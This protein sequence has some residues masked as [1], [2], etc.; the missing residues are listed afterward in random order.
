MLSRI[1]LVLVEAELVCMLSNGYSIGSK[2][3]YSCGPKGQT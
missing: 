3:T 2:T 1:E